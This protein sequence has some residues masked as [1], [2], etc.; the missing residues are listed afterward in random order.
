MKGRGWTL[1]SY[2][3]RPNS[4]HSEKKQQKLKTKQTEKTRSRGRGRDLRSLRF[5]T[6][7]L[8]PYNSAEQIFESSWA[9]GWICTWNLLQG[10]GP[11][12]GWSEYLPWMSRPGPQTLSWLGVCILPYLT[13]FIHTSYLWTPGPLFEQV[14]FIVY[15]GSFFSL[16][17]DPLVLHLGP[18]ALSA[19]VLGCL[20]DVCMCVCSNIYILS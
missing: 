6:L 12:A 15:Y 10:H 20:R 14:V 11:P 17:D 8:R 19:I 4:I 1:E 3:V 2:W 16:S 7:R 9:D 5:L 18:T 13:V